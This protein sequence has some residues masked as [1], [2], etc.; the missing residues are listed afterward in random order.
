[1]KYQAWSKKTTRIILKNCESLEYI[2][3]EGLIHAL[4]F[5]TEV[6]IENENNKK[7]LVIKAYNH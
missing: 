7:V 5:N 1:M 6:L 3:Q 4:K 2:A